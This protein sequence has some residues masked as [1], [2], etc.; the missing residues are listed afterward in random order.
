MLFRLLCHCH[1]VEYQFGI[2]INFIWNHV[3]KFVIA[4]INYCYTSPCKN[5]GTCQ[6]SLNDYRCVCQAKFTGKSCEQGIAY[7]I[8]LIGLPDSTY[9]IS[10]THPTQY[11]H[12]ALSLAC[13]YFPYISQQIL[14]YFKTSR[15]VLNDS[16][17]LFRVSHLKCLPF[18]FK[19]NY[20]EQVWFCGS[21]C[22]DDNDTT[23]AS[24][25]KM[26]RGSQNKKT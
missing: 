14:H 16:L 20:T 24:G 26:H 7:K 10:S 2:K 19:E 23:P 25:K 9:E 8:D 4:D 13:Q 21:I 1:F 18:L 15:H 6:S 11:L 22:P 5:N 12:V 3:L 17:E